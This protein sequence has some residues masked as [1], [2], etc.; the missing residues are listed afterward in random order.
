MRKPLN[1]LGS[2]ASFS[3]SWCRGES[4]FSTLSIRRE[5]E[6][7]ILANKRRLLT[8]CS[9]NL[10]TFATP[11]F[12]ASEHFF[13]LETQGAQPCRS[14][15]CSITSR[16]PA[17]GDKQLLFGE[18]SCGRGSDAAR[19]QVDGPWNVALLEILHAAG[20]NQY[21]A[22][23]PTLQVKPHI[24]CVGFHREFSEKVAL[25]VLWSGG[26]RLQYQRKMRCG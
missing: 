21:K 26:W 5:K 4:V 16:R 14:F 6:G 15:G 9:F 25:C 20:I 3:L 8:K 2:S 1:L 18:V 23:L 22:V 7:E 11:V 12:N 10:S 17:V 24:G 19:G 13:H